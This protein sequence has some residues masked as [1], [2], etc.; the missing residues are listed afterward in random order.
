MRTEMG[1][2][3]KEQAANWTIERGWRRWEQ[4]Y[5]GLLT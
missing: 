2:K 1:A 5:E 3:A 4:A